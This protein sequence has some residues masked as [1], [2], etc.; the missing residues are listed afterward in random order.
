MPIN[1]AGVLYIFFVLKESKPVDNKSVPI[2]DPST[3]ISTISNGI[4][5]QAYEITASQELNPNSK[6]NVSIAGKDV[7]KKSCWRENFSPLA[8]LDSLR[9]VFKK[10][11]FSGRNIVI[12]LLVM[13]FLTVG[14]AFGRFSYL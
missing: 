13:Y 8:A 14:P 10:R 3:K 4:D 2:D 1:I 6:N 7:V 9:V 11:E 12:L 5:N